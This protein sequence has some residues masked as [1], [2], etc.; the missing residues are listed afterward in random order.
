[1][2]SLE[3][4]ELAVLVCVKCQWEVCVVVL[5]MKGMGR[6]GVNLF[7]YLPEKNGLSIENSR[8]IVVRI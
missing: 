8:V 1:M 4:M 5:W 7:L 3:S 2:E 6:A